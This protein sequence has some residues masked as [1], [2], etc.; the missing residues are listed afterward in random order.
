MVNKVLQMGGNIHPL[1]ID[2]SFNDGL[3]LCNPSIFNDNGELIVNVRSVNYTLLHSENKIIYGNRYGPL[4]YINP[5]NDVKLKT[6][7]WRVWLDDDFN[8]NRWNIINTSQFD[9]TP[10]W[11][12]YGLED[13]RIVKWNE[14]LYWTGVRRDV[15]TDGQGR[16]ELS[17]IDEKCNEISRKRIEAP[18][19]TSYCEKN[20]MPIIDLPYH[21]IKWT[22][23]LE[24]VK[25]DTE[26]NT[27]E[28]VISKPLV[29]QL[30]NLRGGTQVIP[31]GKG[32]LCIIH[33]CKLWY[34]AAENRNVL[35]THRWVLFD[36]DWNI[37][38]ISNSFS[39]MN[40]D[41]EFATGMCEYNG[42]LLITFGFQDNCAFLLRI[43]LN[44][45]NE[46]IYE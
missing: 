40:G 46:L 16:M 14:R 2:A 20:W 33:E 13:A 10:V 6:R 41:V 43:P 4:A 26:T 9:I 18:D 44:K 32:H 39:F 42:E 1:I 34:N 17:L 36:K 8:I 11:E 28:V 38:H 24:I 12:F 45:V 21:Y 29:G 3:G 19:P 37:E 23:P 5:E 7:N 31:F 25:V 30:N 22:N 35:Y 27:S 15:K